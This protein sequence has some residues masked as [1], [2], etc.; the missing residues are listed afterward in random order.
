MD[1]NTKMQQLLVNKT[2]FI[3][4]FIIEDEKHRRFECLKEHPEATHK[5]SSHWK[6]AKQDTP[7][8]NYWDVFD[9][10]GK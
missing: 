3:A 5:G 7:P 2:N 4:F 10:D 1:L 6:L 9:S 8:D